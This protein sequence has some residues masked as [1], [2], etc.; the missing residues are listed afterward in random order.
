M[1]QDVELTYNGGWKLLM[2]IKWSGTISNFLRFIQL[3]VLLGIL[4]KICNLG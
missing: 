3:I 1:P 4:Y 2:D